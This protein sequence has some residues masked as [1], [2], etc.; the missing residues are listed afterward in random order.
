M[1]LKIK[2]TQRNFSQEKLLNNSIEDITRRNDKIFMFKK[3][4]FNTLEY[5]TFKLFAFKKSFKPC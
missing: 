4:L 5:I 1:Y 2:V 3:M